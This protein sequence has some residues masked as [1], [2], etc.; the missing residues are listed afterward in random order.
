MKK[1]SRNIF[2][3][4][5][6]SVFFLGL[7]PR[8]FILDKVQT[9]ITGE[10]SRALD[11][12]VSITKMHWVWL[13]LPHLTLVNSNISN[14]NYNLSL[15]KILIYPNWRLILGE[16]SKP[17]KIILDRPRILIKKTLLMPGKSS[18][19]QIPEITF[20]IK[21][22]EL[23]IEP[24]EEYE[25]IFLAGSLKF[26]DIRGRLKL[27]SRNAEIALQA[28]S[29][30]SKNISLQG[31]FNIP[32]KKY[33]LSLDSQDVKLHKSVKA[34]FN[35]RLL[36][37]ESSARIAGTVTGIGLQHIDGDLHG[38]LPCFV[39][40]PQ[41]REI[42]LTCGFADLKLVKSGP[43]LRLGINDL[44]I[45]D[46]Q[47][48][49]SGYIER[50]LSSVPGKNQPAT[51]KPVWTLDLIGSDLDLT[52]I[53]EK[54]LTLWDDN[55]IARTVSNIVLEGRALSAA[56]R[57]SGTAADFKRLDAMIIEADMLNAAIHV[58]AANLN[59]TQANGPIQIKGSTLTGHGLSARLGNSL[60][61]N[62][63]LLLDVGNKRNAF[64]LDIDIEA[65]LKDLPPVLEQFVDHVGFQQ[66]LQ[67]FSAVSGRA[68][69]TLHLGD[70]L[71]NISTRIDIG[72]MQLSTRYEP[73]PEIVII[74]S[75][76]LQVMPEKARWQKVKGLTGRQKISSTSGTISWHTPQAEIDIDELAAQLDGASLHAMLRQTGVLPQ[77]INDML[78]SLEGPIEIIQGTLHGPARQPE[79]WD[80]DLLL[81]SNG[82]TLTSPQLPE[83]LRTERL[84]ATFSQSST[85][86]LEAEIIFLD[87]SFNLNGLL[88]HHFLA[89]WYGM[90]EFNGPVEAKLADWVSRKGWFPEKL[91]PQIPCTMKN[92]QIHWQGSTVAVSGVILHGLAGGTLPMAKLD[93]ENTPEHLHINELTFYAPGQ[94]GRLELDFWR[95]SPHSIKLS[96]DGF[97][98][99]ETINT[100]FQHSSFTKGAFSGDFAINYLADQP[101]NTH[102]EGLL[103]AE[104]LILKTSPGQEPIV[105]TNVNMIGIDRQLR[106]PSLNLAI[107]N[108]HINGSGQLAAAD[109]GLQLDISFTA[110][111]LSK[112]S[113]ANLSQA[114]K[115]SPN[116]FLHDLEEQGPGLQLARGWNITGRI[117][118]DIES[119]ILKRE[120]STPYDGVQPL[121]Y[122]FYDMH[123]D[124][125]LAPDKIS[126]TEIFSAGLCGLNFNG[127]W[128]SDDALGKKFEFSTAQNETLRLENVLPCLGVQQDIIEGE[129]SLQANL[130]K[131]SDTWYGGTLLIR[132]TQG[133]IL[134]L[135]TLS[136]VFKIVNIT[137]LFEEQL[138]YSGKRGFPYSHMDIDT[139]IDN[140]NLILDRAII[141]GEGLN[142]FASGEIHLDDYDAAMTLLV[143]PLKT[144]STMVS[145]VPILGQ[146]IMGEYGSRVSIPVAVKGPMADPVITPLHPEAIGDAVFNMIKDTFMLPYTILKPL[147]KSDGDKNTNQ[148]D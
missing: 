123:G 80:Y 9:K 74:N 38:T 127:F 27:Q 8:F 66:E 62:A 61:R 118:F 22:G 23:E 143:T 103:H 98:A 15:P 77:K 6:F 90:I 89:D 104:N 91:R 94:Q 11:S 75:G 87:Q 122:T 43:L 30:F 40:K 85:E 50:K 86:I 107:G 79:S 24:A 132:S 54:I 7:S 84:S 93:Y 1:L 147:E 32:E 21:K 129:F 70:R 108:E 39:V 134:R 65:D 139:H 46:P 130:M 114:I 148:T 113:L 97:V 52:A 88:Q 29:L 36:P 135:K 126:R 76:T 60:G 57:F 105:V 33:Q 63:Q 58:P 28:S 18:E 55:K 128:Y 124:M 51:A 125:Q 92:M 81:T 141:R 48:N 78:T 144:F 45:K 37:V 110:P 115:D 68:S 35:G 47:V 4:I 119:F 26:S 131:E 71:D 13:P 109:D 53:R 2:F 133:R 120:T 117:G 25:D 5:I 111:L 121:T 49:L 101:E 116:V 44:E 137:D 31:S 146:P 72:D 67:K 12:S 138:D 73:I 42:L 96:W 145:K 95:L 10:I 56:Y 20:T 82:L 19:L 140:N 112:K 69:G 83:P 16:T 102:F 99:A 3:I 100:L 136:R 106:I 59:L 14:T 64:T 17:A 34:L 41:D 142:L